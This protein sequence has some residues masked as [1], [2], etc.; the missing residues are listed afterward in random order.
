MAADQSRVKVRVASSCSEFGQQ[1]LAGWSPRPGLAKP[2]SAGAHAL[3]K[4]DK[5]VSR[6]VSLGQLNNQWCLLGAQAMGA[7]ELPP[8]AS[9]EQFIT[10]H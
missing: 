8:E 3:M 7:P 6:A 5:S 4:L 9:L 2:A 1:R 10:E